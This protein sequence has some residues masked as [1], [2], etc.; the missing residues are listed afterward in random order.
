MRRLTAITAAL[1]FF[2]LCMLPLSGCKKESVAGKGFRFPISAE[3]K[4]IDPQ[5]STD[6][7]SVTMVAAL[8]EGLARL[9]ESGKAVPG[10]ATWTVSDDGLTY[11]FD[12]KDSKWSDGTEVTAQDF[13]YGMQRAVSP[14]TRSSL[15]EQLFDI[16]GARDVNAGKQNVG[17]LGIKAVSDKELVIILVQP[18]ADFPAKTASTPFMPC[19]QSFYEGTGGRYGI[20]SKFLLSNGPFYLKKWTH[21]DSLLLYKNEGYHDAAG[22]LPSTV[23]Y[24]ISEIKDPVGQL[25]LG[26]LDAAPIPADSIPAAKESGLNIITQ[27]DAIQY[28]WMNNSNKEL[29]NT[30]VRQALRD[31]VE[32]DIVNGQLNTE[33]SSPAQGYVSLDSVLSGE[34]NY[35]TDGN[36]ITGKTNAQ[37]AAAELK[38]GLQQLGLSKMSKLKVLCA[39]DDY[40]TNLARYIIQSWQKNLSLYFDIE[41]VKSSE[42]ATRVKVGNYEIALYTATAPGSSALEALKSFVTG[43]TGNISH[44]S[45]ADFD[46]KVSALTVGTASRNDMEA[47]ESQLWNACPS[48]PL[49]F[50]KTY[51]GIPSTDSGIIVR[52]FGGGAFGAPYDFR[53]AGKRD[54]K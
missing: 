26:N 1:L 54:K 10:A 22:I 46:K 32:W 35:R 18:N 12:L 23:R 21:N 3:P 5:V 51:V 40:S 30:F 15:A 52:S 27:E 7:A 6:A 44:F 8:F 48:I 47:L 53:G 31:A 11:T 49:S 4:Q 42:L 20:E 2:I 25:K 39:D 16:Q 43:T 33:V 41:P 13:V 24:M 36:A 17:E 34:E 19:K 37:Q 9:D 38:S 14:S 45:D 28:I 29:S 50:E